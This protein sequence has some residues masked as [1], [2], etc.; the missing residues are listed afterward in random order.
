MSFVYM[1]KKMAPRVYEGAPPASPHPVFYYRRSATQQVLEEQQRLYQEISASLAELQRSVSAQHKQQQQL[2]E[3]WNERMEQDE[4]AKQ[5]ITDSLV[6]QEEATKKLSQQLAAR[7]QL[8]QGLLARLEGQE[9]LYQKL[10]EKLELQDVFQETV[11][12]R[13]EAQEATQYKMTRQL[14]SL[15]EAL[16]ER[17][18]F[19]VDTMK[20]LMHSLFSRHERKKA[21]EEQP[22][23]EKKLV[24][25]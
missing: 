8:Y 14:D 15:K 19:I 7:E 23:Q 11:I 1:N 5:A 18:S 22:E 20:Q 10:I 6:L 13:L 12:E 3:R 16:Y 4:I 9:K 2:Y 24:H 25:L 17:C 21:T